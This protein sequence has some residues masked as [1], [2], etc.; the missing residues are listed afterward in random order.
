MLES[1]A[2]TW[3]AKRTTLHFFWKTFRKHIQHYAYCD[4]EAPGD[5]PSNAA[6]LPSSEATISVPNSKT[7]PSSAISFDHLYP[8][9]GIC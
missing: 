9:T 5:A 1:F 6:M 3:F 7:P 8:L 4:V 2:L